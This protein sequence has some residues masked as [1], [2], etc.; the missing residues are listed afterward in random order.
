M[1]VKGDR[2]T[3][4]GIVMKIV[5]MGYSG[6]GKST[7]ARKLSDDY[8]IDV[9]HLDKV[10]HLPYW[11]ERDLEDE[12]EIVKQFLDSHLSW[13]IDGNY[14]KLSY[15]R[16]LAEADIIVILLFN[17]F[18]SLY[19]V[20]KRYHRYKGRTRPDMSEGCQE[21]IDFEFIKWILWNGRTYE[22]RLHFQKIKK[23]YPDKVVI[24]KNQKQIE[25]FELTIKR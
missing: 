25:K 10:H 2:F 7:L 8:H 4:G 3:I 18:H 16:R 19:R 5:I 21:K 23:Q 22:K 12:K 6:S 9:L 13:V 11:K 17:R 20:L 1:I 15:N 14:F 24:L